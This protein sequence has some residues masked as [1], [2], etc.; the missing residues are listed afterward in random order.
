VAG[1][2]LFDFGVYVRRVVAFAGLTSA[3]LAAKLFAPGPV[4]VV[5]TDKS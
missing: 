5:L 1:I 2:Q 4:R 3:A